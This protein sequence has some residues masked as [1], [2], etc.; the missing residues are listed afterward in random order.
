MRHPRLTAYSSR[1]F[2]STTAIRLIRPT[3]SICIGLFYFSAILT[4]ITS[5]TLKYHHAHTDVR[6][7][8]KDNQT[9]LHY[10]CEGGHVQL[11]KYL[12]EELKCDVGE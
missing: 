2:A 5:L 7:K 9:P 10:A 8:D 4:I 12:V 11:V 6:D 1:K 3:I